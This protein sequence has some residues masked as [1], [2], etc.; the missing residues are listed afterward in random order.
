[1][2]LLN[3]HTHNRKEG[4]MLI[5]VIIAGM[6]IIFVSLAIA[7]GVASSV[8]GISQTAAKTTAVYLSREVVDALRAIVI[9]NWHNVSD[10]ATSTAY[11]ATTSAG[12]WVTA[13]GSEQVVVNNVTYTR[14]FSLSDICR[15][16]GT[17]AIET[18][19]ATA[20][21]DSSSIKATT[22]VS[23]T[24]LAGRP[25]EFSQAIYFSRYG[26]E[27]FPQTDWSGA[28]D[29]NAVIST[30]TG[31]S[32]YGTSSN[33]DTTGAAGQFMLQTQ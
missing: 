17:K 9:E 16:E 18:C 29:I 25:I 19:S 32:G 20:S 5:E 15:N 4:Q 6:I 21:L 28:S 23:G 8:R 7:Q 22:T 24:D 3:V 12:K 27:L 31:L 33:I 13:A 11:Y 30:S 2:Q 10:L 26:N 14:S 1:M